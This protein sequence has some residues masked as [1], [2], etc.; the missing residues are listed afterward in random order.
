M[1]GYKMVSMYST[2]YCR[3]LSQEPINES[4]ILFTD[5][6]LSILG[7]QSFIREWTHINEYSYPCRLLAWKYI[8]VSASL[9][10]D[11]MQ[12][13]TDQ[14]LR[15]DQTEGKCVGFILQV[16]LLY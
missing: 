5:N 8:S 2:T 11:V 10:A 6:E 9:C 7:V 14:P 12:F 3:F 13:M 16:T 1:N 15:K 4:L